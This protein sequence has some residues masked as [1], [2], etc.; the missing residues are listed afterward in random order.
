MNRKSIVTLLLSL[1]CCF[2]MTITAFAA[3]DTGVDDLTPDSELT[4][5]RTS[6]VICGGEDASSSDAAQEDLTLSGP[7]AASAKTGA[8][9][10]S[11]ESGSKGD[12]LG[13]FTTTGYCNCSKCNSSGFSLTYSGTVPTADHTI[14]ADLDLYPIGTKLMI[15]DIIYTVEDKGS[16]VEG[17]WLDVYY[18][19]H[20][21]AVAHGMK[22]EE[23]FAVEP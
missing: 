4:N 18:D 7:G 2:A 22:T 17:N 8:A 23:V 1:L 16:H 11:G 10:G 20:E 3:A 12:S 9:S 14:S 15:G 13:L 21:L 19:T 6:I 5:G